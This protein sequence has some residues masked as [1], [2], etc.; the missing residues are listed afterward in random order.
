MVSKPLNRAKKSIELGQS[1]Y[2]AQK[3]WV[4]KTSKK[5]QYRQICKEYIVSTL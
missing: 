3:M 4:I 2:F 1:L 5:V